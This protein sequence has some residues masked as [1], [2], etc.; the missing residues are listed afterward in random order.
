MKLNWDKIN[1]SGAE[2]DRERKKKGHV[3]PTQK[4]KK[5]TKQ[6]GRRPCVREKDEWQRVDFL[7]FFKFLFFQ[8]FLLR[9][10]KI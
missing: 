6:K 2:T 4:E 8:I 3:G 1:C 10:T 7:F 5:K 9:F